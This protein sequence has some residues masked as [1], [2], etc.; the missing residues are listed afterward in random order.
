MNHDDDDNHN[1]NTEQSPLKDD[2]AEGNNIDFE[3]DTIFHQTT[4]MKK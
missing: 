3:T 1:I 2:K 4:M